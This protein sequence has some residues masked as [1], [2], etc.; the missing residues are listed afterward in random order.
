MMER[1]TVAATP[2]KSVQ[3]H[4]LDDLSIANEEIADTDRIRRVSDRSSS[5][6]TRR[7]SNGEHPRQTGARRYLYG[8][9][10]TAEPK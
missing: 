9:Y 8:R 1:P 4:L 2:N 7:L 3:D 5:G 6:I 10:Y